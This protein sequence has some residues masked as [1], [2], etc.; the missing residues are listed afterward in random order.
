M[1]SKYCTLFIDQFP[2]DPIAFRARSPV[3]SGGAGA[4]RTRRAQNFDAEFWNSGNRRTNSK[5]AR[6]SRRRGSRD[7]GPRVDAKPDDAI[8]RDGGRRAAV[9]MAVVTIT[10]VAAAFCLSG[11]ALTVLNKQ[12]MGFFPAPNAVLFAQNAVTLVLL[13]FGKSVLSLQIEPVRRHKAKRWFALVLLFYAMLA[14]SMLALKFVTATTLIVQR[15]L[16]T[17]T[18]AI[19]DYFCLGTVQT[20]PR[21]LA[22]LGMCVGSLVYAS[23]DLD[24]ASNFDFTGYAWLAVNVA[25]TT[26]YQIKVK[27]LVNELDMNSW[28]MAYY[29][30]LLSLPVC[31][32]V[33]FAQRENETLQK[34]M[35]SGATKSQCVALFVSCTLGFCLSVSAFQ[36]NRLITPTSITILNNTNKFALIFFTAYFMDYSTLSESTVAGAAIVMICAAHYS[37]AGTKK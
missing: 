28:T 25:A 13:A 22:I 15:N 27:S 6:V 37:F 16:G 14:S 18:I 19:A 29:N 31:A 20:K 2:D 17:V 10:L 5:R 7:G 9:A 12:I 11:S 8:A 36:L 24:A 33:G 32:I 23:G 1:L 3:R 35:A 21:I 26:A 34:F 4:S 30:N